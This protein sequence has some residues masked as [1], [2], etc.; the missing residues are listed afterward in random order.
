MSKS[1]GNTVEPQAVMKEYG[2]DILRLWVASCDYWDDQRLGPDIL[3]SVADAYRK[4]RNT[5]RWM[6]GTLA[7]FP[8]VA[9]DS[10]AGSRPDPTQLPELERY[11]LHQLAMLGPQIDEAYATYDYKRVVAALAQF[12]N[13][14]LS[15]FYFDVRKDALYCEAP[16][17]PKRRAAL[18]CVEEIFRCTTVWLAPILVFTAEEAWLSR[19]GQDAKSVHLEQFPKLPAAW[20]DDALDRRWTMIRDVRRAVTG[21][22][23][24]ERAAKRIGASL[25]AA[26]TVHVQV[27]DADYQALVSPAVGFAD[28]CITSGITVLRGPG[29]GDAFRLHD[30]PNVAV[31]P[32][33]AEGKKCARS[34]RYTSDVGSDPKYPD[35][36][37][38][39]AAVM[40]KRLMIDF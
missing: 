23:E 40:R 16:S 38:R 32:K 7:H 19:Y 31:Q 17:S 34:W 5:L 36:S 26:P 27:D 10:P 24:V 21:A 18:Q 9:S 20:R 37:A 14:D 1:L 30:L 12:M 13:T 2:A 15:A 8:V 6:L 35:L 11:M 22:L 4:T 29:P 28:V 25:E 39:D 33:R 3:K